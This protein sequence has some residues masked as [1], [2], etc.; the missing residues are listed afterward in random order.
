MGC[1][2]K[3][4]DQSYSGTARFRYE[5][6]V[7]ALEDGDYLEAVRQFSFV[8][9]KFA[10]SKYAALSELRMADAY[11]Q[12]EKFIEAIDAYQTFAQSRPNHEQTQYALFQVA[13]S[14]YEQLPSSFFLFPPPHE[15]DRGA[16]HDAA[17]ALNAYLSRFPEGEYAATARQRLI[18][19]RGALADHELYVARF[20]LREARPASA[21]GRLEKVFREFED[22]PKQWKAGTALLVDVYEQLA[23]APLAVATAKALIAKHPHSDEA[24]R[25]RRRLPH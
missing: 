13:L 9:N 19:C 1:G 7:E 16:T 2:P 17:R 3:N 12:Q 21:R 20:Y 24:E 5:Q 18:S 14:Y 25:A 6:G 23:E 15:R 11:F 10:Y 8:K 4:L 22:T